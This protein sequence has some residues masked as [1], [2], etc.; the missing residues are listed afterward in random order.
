M[1]IVYWVGVVVSATFASFTS[2]PSAAFIPTR[3]E[4]TSPPFVPQAQK[5]TVLAPSGTLNRPY[6]VTVHSL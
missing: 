6:T 1:S 2:K 3:K 5:D 4:T